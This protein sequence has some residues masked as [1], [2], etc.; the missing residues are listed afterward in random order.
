[1]ALAGIALV[2][3]RLDELE[4]ARIHLETALHIAPE[5]PELLLCTGN[6]HYM[7][8][9]LRAA[10][11]YYLTAL[12]HR[13]GWAP[14]IKNLALACEDLGRPSEARLLWESIVDDESYGR[15]ARQ[16]IRD[17]PE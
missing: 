12:S 15:E 7:A 11:S 3:M 17:L 13:P 10:R 6:V 2:E 16:R 1:M 8:A 14:A 4:P 9:D 5:D